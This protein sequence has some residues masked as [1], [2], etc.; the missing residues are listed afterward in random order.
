M[1]NLVFFDDR[2]EYQVG[3]E[4]IPS[5]SEILRFITRE[6]YSTVSQYTLDNAA[7]RGK[8]VHAATENLDRYGE[9]QIDADIQP[10]I[11]AYVKWRK[12]YD[13]QWSRIEYACYHPDLMYAGTL[14]RY[15]TIQG[16]QYIVDIKTTSKLHTNRETAQLNGYKMLAEANALKVDKL[17]IL[18]LKKDGKYTFKPIDNDPTLFN[19]CLAIHNATAKRRRK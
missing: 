4:I 9:V 1:A 8:R 14:D 17:A 10:Y 15:G 18:Q 19:A 12:D 5:V 3:G 13:P 6:L 16:E 7:D 2:H 11:E